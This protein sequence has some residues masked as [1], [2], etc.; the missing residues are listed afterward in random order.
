MK[1][2]AGV[3]SPKYSI[4]N[5][6]F[7]TSNILSPKAF[8]G[9]GIGYI[10]S[11]NI[12][13]DLVFTI[14]NRNTLKNHSDDHEDTRDI[15]QTFSSKTLMFNTN[16]TFAPG[17]TFRPYVS[18]GLGLAY[19]TSGNY[20]GNT[21]YKTP[22]T[23]Y[24]GIETSPHSSKLRFAHSFGAGIKTEITE[25]S[26]VDLFYRYMNLGS[27]SPV[28]IT[29]KTHSRTDLVNPGRL[30]SHDFGISFTYKF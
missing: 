27:A 11:E 23:P 6:V 26:S 19:N 17:N 14:R 8:F 28:S 24:N 10:F 30:K 1:F 13:S 15:K 9:A 4:N 21:F 3:S 22:T 2:D 20:Y 12:S 7:Y 16:Y 18:A 5:E 25:K 29:D